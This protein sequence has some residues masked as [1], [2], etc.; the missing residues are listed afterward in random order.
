[1]TEKAIQLIM[2]RL[3]VDRERAIVIYKGMKA[4]QGHLKGVRAKNIT[5]FGTPRVSR[6]AV[7]GRY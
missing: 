3:E 4:A 7:T 6:S 5:A 2:Y 1:M